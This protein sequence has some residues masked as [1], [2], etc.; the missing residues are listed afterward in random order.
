[1]GNFGCC[2]GKQPTIE[3]TNPMPPLA[4]TEDC[5]ILEAKLLSPCENLQN[6]PKDA[7]KKK[8]K[9]KKTSEKEEP[10]LK[11]KT[12]EMM[13]ISREDFVQF[14]QENIEN[15]YLIISLLG[16]GSF[17][18]VYKAQHRLT[19]TYRAV[20]VLKK[21]NLEV[22]ARNKLLSEVEIMKSLNHPNILKVFEVYEDSV[23]I[24]I[25]TEL[26]TGGEL[27]DKIVASKGFSEN[28]A[29]FYMYQIISAV[30]SCHSKGIV[31]RDLKPENILFIEDSESSALKII[32]F[33]TSKKIDPQSTLSSL[34]GTV[35]FT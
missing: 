7:K 23:S 17:G 29:A 6:F 33:G 31:H 15:S 2:Q 20:K 26:C 32:D 14:K 11:H 35:I 10:T 13:R 3:E 1:M 9:A 27:F 25:I 4:Q 12:S 21:L 16:K 8:P 30:Q 22:N 5:P 18:C 24:N 28:K 19:Q 34:T